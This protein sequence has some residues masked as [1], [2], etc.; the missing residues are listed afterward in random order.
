MTA[1]TGHNRVGMPDPRESVGD[2]LPDQFGDIDDQTGSGMGWIPGYP[3]LAGA[4]A[5]GVV[6]P[7]VRLAVDDSMQRG[8]R[9]L[10]FL[11]QGCLAARRSSASGQGS[12][13]APADRFCHGD[14]TCP[15][16]GAGG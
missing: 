10:R 16:A 1:S 11:G 14:L 13:P 8:R 7:A 2:G 3:D 5:D 12:E 9:S 6:Q 4:H 15:A